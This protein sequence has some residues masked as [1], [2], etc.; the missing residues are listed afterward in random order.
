[1]EEIDRALAALGN[2]AVLGANIPDLEVMPTESKALND[3]ILACGGLPRGRAVEVYA[4]SSVGKSTF[5]QWLAGQVQAK[6]WDISF[7]DGTGIKRKGTVCWFDAER[8]MMKDYAKGSGMDLSQ[9]ILPEI[10][11]G[12]DTLYKL[13]QCIALDV[14]DLIVL[15]S[16]QAVIPDEIADV[17]GSRSMNQ[18]LAASKMWAQFFGELQ[19]GFKIRD[20]AGVLIKSKCPEYV[21]NVSADDEGRGAPKEGQVTNFHKLGSKKCCLIFVNHARVKISTGFSRGPKTYTP[22]GDEKDFAFAIRIE[23]KSKGNKMGKTKGERILKWRDVE[24]KA[25]KNKLGM[26]LRSHDFGLGIDGRLILDQ[27]D[28]HDVELDMEADPDEEEEQA[29]EEL[30]EKQLGGNV[31]LESIQ[32]RMKKLKKEK[33]KKDG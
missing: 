7:R 12:N 11:L 5:C 3:D 27:S 30:K 31:T 33:E 17:Q 18:R 25:T 13:K 20:A 16:I 32:E 8:S 15:D 4:K 24:F 9:V 10:G 29:I 14:F 28:M 2:A 1:M 26:P 23:L 21:Y 6:E 19:G 22:G